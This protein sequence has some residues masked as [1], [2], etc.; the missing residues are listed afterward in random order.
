MEN[1]EKM[2]VLDETYLP[3]MAELYKAAFSGEPWCDDWSDSTQLAAYMKEI[4]CNYGALNYG[5]MINGKLSAI[6]IG[7]VRH[8]WEG[9]EYK[10]EEFCVSPDEQGRGAGTRFMK[11]IEEDIL[12]RGMTGIYLETDSD[13]PAYDFYRK[14]GFGDM[15]THVSLYKELK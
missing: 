15:H 11:M 12:K 6:S 9:T 2:I 14:I 8:W 3:Q 13:K 7:S 4:S 10:I 1:T 5:L